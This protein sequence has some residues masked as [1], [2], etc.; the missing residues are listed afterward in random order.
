[1]SRIICA[2][3]ALFTACLGVLTLSTP[4]AAYSEAE[5][6][7]LAPLPHLTAEAVVSGEFTKQVA[8]FSADHVPFRT[9]LLQMHATS[10]ILLGRNET[11]DTFVCPDGYLVRRL[12]LQDT[13]C[14]DRSLQ[15]ASNIRSKLISGGIP[16]VFVCAPRAID[17]L[18][19][20]LP[21]GYPKD[22]ADNL[23]KHLNTHAPA[24]LFP[25]AL[26]GQKAALGEAVFFHTDHHWTPL[27][28]YYVY[29]SLGKH[30][31]YTPYD[32][33]D[34]TA[35]QITADFMGTSASRAS[36]PF[37]R[38]DA[39]ICYRY[40]ADADLFVTDLSTGTVKKGLY[41]EEFLTKKDKYAYFLGGNFAHLRITGTP[42]K[43]RLLLIK[44][45]YANCM[46]PFLARHFNID[47]VDFRYVRGDATAFFHTLL[48][49]NQFDAALL[50]LNAE[51]LSTD[52]S[53]TPFSG[54]SIDLK[55]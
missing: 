15:S 35:K 27:G 55:G 42:D 43:P 33:N 6:R 48:K 17:V 38:P 20:L 49:E 44:D 14:L 53:L 41:R 52:R 13:A 45:S 19:D 11:G 1:M 30:L 18:C 34:F 3:F 7:Y 8:T 50:L 2:L 22:S 4:Y 10:E 26:L 37:V 28:A 9:A 39:I 23:Q 12:E 29:Q 25:A 51:T 32:I 16:A 36:Y 54:I 24:A 5:N 47:L 31:G 40:D 21:A 46:V